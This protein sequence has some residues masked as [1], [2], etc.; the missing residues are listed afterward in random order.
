M[1]LYYLSAEELSQNLIYLE[2]GFQVEKE[3]WLFIAGIWEVWE[4][5]FM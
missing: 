1:D 4:L 2:M 5:F 3:F